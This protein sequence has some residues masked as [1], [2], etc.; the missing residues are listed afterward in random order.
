MRE[1]TFEAIGPLTYTPK[2]ARELGAAGWVA[3]RKRGEPIWWRD[4]LGLVGKMRTGEAWHL[5][6]KRKAWID[7]PTD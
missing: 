1:S 7:D 2:L 5:M 6:M 3:E 4:P